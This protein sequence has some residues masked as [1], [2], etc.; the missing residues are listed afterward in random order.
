MHLILLFNCRS[1][2]LTNVNIVLKLLFT[3]VVLILYVW[4]NT[5][6]V[7]LER[8]LL[9]LFIWSE[10]SW[11][12]WH[13][14][15]CSCVCTSS[16]SLQPLT[17]H[18]SAH[19]R[20]TILEML[21]LFRTS[22]GFFNQVYCYWLLRDCVKII[23]KANISAKKNYYFTI[24]SYTDASLSRGHSFWWESWVEGVD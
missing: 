19:E 7:C 9:K 12:S 18:S 8:V 23:S 24:T 10:V 16:K 2:I 17:M 4:N 20:F 14:R 15:G 11:F 13:R 6:V 22:T 1:K 5:T 21:K 3:A